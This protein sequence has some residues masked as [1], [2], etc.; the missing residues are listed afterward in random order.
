MIKIKNEIVFMGFTNKNS[1]I[2]YKNKKNEKKCEHTSLIPIQ[3]HGKVE[4]NFG[5]FVHFFY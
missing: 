5:D 3:L 4:V 2:N 1:I